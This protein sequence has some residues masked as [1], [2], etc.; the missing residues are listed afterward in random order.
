[1]R[2]ETKK[3]KF[4]THHW[5]RTGF[6]TSFDSLLCS[7][8]KERDRAALTSPI[9]QTCFLAGLVTGD[10]SPPLFCRIPINTQSQDLAL[11]HHRHLIP[12]QATHHYQPTT[13]VHPRATYTAPRH[14]TAF[15]PR[16]TPPTPHHRSPFANPACRSEDYSPMLSNHTK[17]QRT[18]K[19]KRIKIKTSA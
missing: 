10:P 5:A 7:R 15:H 18:K 17:R 12:R 6:L 2:D 11:P 9:N 14:P 8:E 16:H 19:E 1:M 13:I 3:T 4:P